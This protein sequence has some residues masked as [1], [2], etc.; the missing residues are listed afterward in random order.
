MNRE[1]IVV[2]K[3]PFLFLK[4]LIIVE[5]FFALL[6]FL[7]VTLASLRQSYEGSALSGTVSYNLLLAIV[8]TTLQI[9]ILIISF[10]VW[11]FPAYYID[12]ERITLRRANLFEDKTVFE[13]QALRR[14]EVRQGA[15]ARR[16]DYGT[17]VIEAEGKASPALVRDIPSPAA[18]AE[19]IEALVEPEPA[20]RPAIEFESASELIARGEGQSVEFKSSLMWDYRRKM[21][22]KALYEPV[23]KNVVGFMNATG[24][25]VIIGVDDDGQVLGLDAD[26]QSMRKPDPDGYE[27]VFNQAFNKMVGVEYRRFVALSFPQIEGKEICLISV[28]PSSQPAYLQYKGDET[29]YLRAG[30]ASQPLTVSQA[31]RYIRDHFKD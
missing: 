27:N 18:Y 13:T 16:L 2:R 15:V 14:I 11:Y 8:M 30:N 21:V 3:T 25:V 24:G 28:Q 19:R 7:V 1:E 10:V 5:F 9:L 17:L 6:P 26:Y 12:R 29:F 4:W 20:A 23:M 31:A 22:N